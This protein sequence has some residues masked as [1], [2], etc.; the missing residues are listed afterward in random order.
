MSIDTETMQVIERCVARALSNA[1]S[2]KGASDE[3]AKGVTQYVGARYVPLFAEPL[4]WDKTKSYE[5]LTI[6]LH[7]G[8]SY[9][10]R[11]YVPAGVEIDN[12][13]FWAITG[14]YNAQVEQYRQ[15]VKAIDVRVT[16]NAKAID[17]EVTNRTNADYT[18][19]T[20]IDAEKTRAEGAEQTLQ[21]NIDAEKTRAE[22]AEQTLQTNI[23]AEKTRAKGAEQTLQT[24][25]NMNLSVE[26]L[27]ASTS[28][29]NTE[30]FRTADSLC[31]IYS[32]TDNVYP[33][34]GSIDLTNDISN[35][36]V[37]VTENCEY[38]FKY[39]KRDIK[40]DN[41]SVNGNDKAK[42][43][44]LGSE[45]NP[46]DTSY[47]AAING[48][49]IV[50]CIEACVDTGEVRTLIHD[51]FVGYSKIG[52]KY[53][54][55]DCKGGEIVCVDCDTGIKLNSNTYLTSVHPWQLN[56]T[57][58]HGID[59]TN[60]QY[61]YI[62]DYIADTVDVAIHST[63]SSSYVH[64][65]NMVALNNANVPGALTDTSRII[66]LYSNKCVIIIDS[67]IV[68]AHV[69][70]NYYK[71]TSD[72]RYNSRNSIKVYHC[73]NN[74]ATYNDLI[75]FGT[76][77]ISY[78][79]VSKLISVESNSTSNELA[80]VKIKNGVIEGIA[81]VYY[82]SLEANDKIKITVNTDYN[83]R[84]RPHASML[85]NAL[86]NADSLIIY[87]DNGKSITM[88]AKSTITNV[89]FYITFSFS[90]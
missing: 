58:T 76:S 29:D 20:N 53:S 77:D 60:C 8:N 40:I 89:G 49:S 18:L 51:T 71:M 61:V 62:S 38:A 46:T 37:I 32:T 34:K 25:I 73:T 17:T 87:S 33:I 3:I 13:S 86:N 55:T 7:Q 41:V 83:K 64:I 10:S 52:V 39:N 68:D 59:I 30:I 50:N 16:A 2:L 85:T 88:Q 27:G 70:Y 12:D 9:T 48:S 66:D 19:Q 75:Y 63:D 82:D 36:H 65:N 11:Q 80:Q 56:K 45:T 54:T 42:T 79:D 26:Q 35:V 72:E 78:Q 23:D 67:L 4:E 28:I 47:L 5:P 14:N 21:T 90:V 15:E 74:N 84:L 69:P 24:K 57:N 43:G 31:G 44:I 81:Y 22:G 6:V 1:T